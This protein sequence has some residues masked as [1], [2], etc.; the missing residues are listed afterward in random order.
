MKFAESD[1]ECLGAP[2]LMREGGGSFIFR[3]DFEID[4]RNAYSSSLSILNWS[5]SV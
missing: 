2:L 1:L 5:P 4:S 3:F